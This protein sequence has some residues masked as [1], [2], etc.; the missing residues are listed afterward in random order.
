MI[1]LQLTTELTPKPLQ[2][3]NDKIEASLNSDDIDDKHVLEL[4]IE[5]DTL[6]QQLIDEWPDED[7]LKVF[8]EQEIASNTLLLE[9]TQVLRKEVENS[10]GKLVRGRKAIK[11]Y[12]R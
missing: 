2:I 8:A 12:H 1:K 10:L 6:I 4:I 3:I 11:Q 5:R 7:S 9:H